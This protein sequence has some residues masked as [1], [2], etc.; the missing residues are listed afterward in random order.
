MD[1][2]ILNFKE[3]TL[4]FNFKNEFFVLDVSNIEEDHWDTITCK[5]NIPYDINLWYCDL[6]EVWKLGIYDL[7][8]VEKTV[9]V[10]TLVCS[11]IVEPIEYKDNFLCENLST[12]PKIKTEDKH[13][14]L[15]EKNKIVLKGVFAWMLY[16]NIVITTISYLIKF[17]IFIVTLLK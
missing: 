16:A 6:D 2:A 8:T 12:P 17:L 7:K 4:V 1:T 11:Y 14:I 5:D 3:R 15:F 9:E 10:N 13:N